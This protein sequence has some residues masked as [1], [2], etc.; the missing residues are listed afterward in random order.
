M[1]LVDWL[2]GWG[3]GK[4]NYI[5]C[6][7]SL[8][9]E[10]SGG[11]T[12]IYKRG[13]GMLGKRMGSLKKGG[14]YPLYDYET[15]QCNVLF[16][17]IDVKFSEKFLKAMGCSR[18]FFSTN[19]VHSN[20][21]FNKIVKLWRTSFFRN[22]QF[23]VSWELHVKVFLNYPWQSDLICVW[24]RHLLFI[25]LLIRYFRSDYLWVFTRISTAFG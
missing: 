3:L 24:L 16:L 15:L 10:K 20:F 5:K 25:K 13:R 22:N 9:N 11:E 6:L 21:S 4:V 2:L 17:N 19:L 12:K 1:T 14:C 18:D 23:F 7:K 8:W